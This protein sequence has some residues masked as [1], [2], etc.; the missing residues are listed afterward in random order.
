MKEPEHVTKAAEGLEVSLN[1]G[2]T[3][4]QQMALEVPTALVRCDQL[5]VLLDYLYC[6]A[7]SEDIP[8]RPFVV[9]GDEGNILYDSR[10]ETV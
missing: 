4:S 5:R 3:Y 6:I 7:H 2:F 8:G 9:L 1:L 10:K